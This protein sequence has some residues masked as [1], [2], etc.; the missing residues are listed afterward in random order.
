MIIILVLSSLQ[1]GISQRKNKNIND[2]IEAQRVA[3]ITKQLDLTVQESQVFWPIYN[4]YSEK[5]KKLRSDLKSNIKIQNMTEDEAKQAIVK[6]F[7]L[8]AMELDLKKELNNQLTGVIPATK[9]VKLP[10]VERRF[11]QKLLERI[12]DRREKRSLRK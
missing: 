12:K 2:N 1:M 11:K 4:K 8:Q 5:L 6:S 10:F 3:F 9:I 7:E